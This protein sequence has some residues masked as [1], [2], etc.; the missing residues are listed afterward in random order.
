MD[1]RLAVL[2]GVMSL[3]GGEYQSDGFNLNR[4]DIAGRLI[5]SVGAVQFD[6]RIVGSELRMTYAFNQW[7]RFNPVVDFS[8]TDK[9]GAWAGIG[10]YQQFDF[11]FGAQQYFAGFHFAPG[12]YIQ[13]GE[14]DL[15]YPLEFRSGVEIGV[16]LRND[17]QISLSYDHRSN[18]DIMEVNPGLETIQIRFSRA[19]Y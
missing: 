17:W 18:A 12:I 2:F 14:V 4:A 9:G 3:F 1:G 13:G 16:R 19:F 11:D 7:G 15:G 8:I 5:T 6:R 10:L